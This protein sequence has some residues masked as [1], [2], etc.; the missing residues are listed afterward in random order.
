MFDKNPFAFLYSAVVIFPVLSFFLVKL[1]TCFLRSNACKGIY[2]IKP[3]RIKYL[4][5]YTGKFQVSIPGNLELEELDIREEIEDA[6]EPPISPGKQLPKT[7]PVMRKSTS[8]KRIN[9]SL[10]TSSL[11]D[12]PVVEGLELSMI[13]SG[14]YCF[15]GL[16]LKIKN[17]DASPI[18]AVLVD[19]I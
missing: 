1:E 12:I 11:K 16:P 13:S 4:I 5:V 14:R 18:R 3:K 9:R 17:G 8:E 2:A 19:K 6:P 10:L 15:I 7:R